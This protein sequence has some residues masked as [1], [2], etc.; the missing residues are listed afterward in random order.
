MVLRRLVGEEKV[1]SREKVLPR[2]RV[3]SM[4]RR[5]YG[6]ARDRKQALIGRQPGI[7]FIIF[8]FMSYFRFVCFFFFFVYCLVFQML[9]KRE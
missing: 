3:K 1:L 8:P 9:N 5:S 6:Q 7:L 2:R 4:L